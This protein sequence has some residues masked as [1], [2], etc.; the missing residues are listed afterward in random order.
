MFKFNRSAFESFQIQITITMSSPQV[1][2]T[3]TFSS[4]KVYLKAQ[5]S[6]TV[7]ATECLE[8]FPF[9]QMENSGFSKSTDYK[10]YAE[11]AWDKMYL[12]IV[13]SGTQ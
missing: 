2:T 8:G 9:A 6:R 1:Q 11:N 7:I 3:Y 12:Y 13:L 10:K 5:V 4:C